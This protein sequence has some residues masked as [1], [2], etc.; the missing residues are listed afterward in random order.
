MSKVT[1]TVKKLAQDELEVSVVL[2]GKPEAVVSAMVNGFPLK[3]LESLRDAF[4]NELRQRKG[5]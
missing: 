4:D 1:T 2:R 5:R 3:A